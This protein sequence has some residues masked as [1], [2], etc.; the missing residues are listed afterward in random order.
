MTLTL[1][2]VALVI[3]SFAGLIQLVRRIRGEK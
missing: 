2:D 1:L 3:V